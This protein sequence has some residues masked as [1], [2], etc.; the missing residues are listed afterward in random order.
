[1]NNVKTIQAPEGT[2]EVASAL[3]EIFGG[4]VGAWLL[5]L[6]LGGLTALAHATELAAVPFILTFV[7][8][9]LDAV[10][11]TILAIKT[12]GWASVKPWRWV[13]G[14][15]MKGVVGGLSMVLVGI[16]DVW[17]T[18]STPGEMSPALYVVAG[19]M[20]G[21]VAIDAA[22]K[23]DAIWNVGLAAALTRH[24]PRLFGGKKEEGTV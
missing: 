9:G 10:L 21:A 11:G 13:S 24:F 2:G 23:V 5:K 22:R 14:P 3:N 17:V 19:V 4:S 6:T 7:M 8:L 16:I 20:M 1:M 18:K 15:T 12:G